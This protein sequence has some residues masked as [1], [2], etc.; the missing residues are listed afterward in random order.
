MKRAGSVSSRLPKVS[1]PQR[2]EPTPAFRSISRLRSVIL[3]CT[4]QPC[5][6]GKVKRN[7]IEASA[8]TTRRPMSGSSPPRSPVE[9]DVE[10]DSARLDV[11]EDRAF[12]PIE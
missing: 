12:E 9:E 3:Y 7:P 6:R 1:A 10:R 2:W 8:T 11:G 4:N 5:M